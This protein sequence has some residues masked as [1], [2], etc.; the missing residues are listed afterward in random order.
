MIL[1]GY[2]PVWMSEE[3]DML[4]E[5]AGRFAREEIAPKDAEWRQQHQVDHATW[6]L[7]GELGLLLTDVPESYGGAGGHF[8]HEAVIYRALASVSD[9]AFVA[10]RSVHAIVSHYL[11]ACGTEAQ[12]QRWL[13]AMASG[14]CIGG[15]AMTEPGAGSDLQGVRTK[16]EKRG[17]N[18]LI[19]GAK[20]FISNGATAGMIIVVAKTDPSLGAK[21]VSLFLL[22]TATQ[23]FRVG[24]VLD[25]IGL[26]GQDTCELF[27]DD[28]LV[29]AA[30]LL[31][32]VE[33]MGFAQLMQQ[34]PYERSI[35]S[36]SAAASI[37]RALQLAVEY[38]RE[39]TVFGKPL[40]EMQNTRF[41][42]AEVKTVATV[43]RIF[44]DFL[45][46]RVIKG[47][48]DSVTASMGKWWSTEAQCQAV[49]AC[50][51]LFGGYGYMK[52]YP[53]ARMYADARVQ[54]IYGG[55]NEI[56]KELIARSL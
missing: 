56:M 48:L 33:G 10:G 44:N 34:L 35:I 40:I 18:Y 26:D 37:E 52:E 39:R 55:A 29:P 14:A 20:T 53:I 31:G 9:S 22:D 41:E 21:G 27:F 13:P 4:S 36:V 54:K 16:A 6:N 17:D 8:G 11:L 15:I 12:R 24:R 5:A 51:Q 2:R 1:P 7:A 43:A 3:L 46:E 38:T 25:K 19:N 47:E 23:G 45:I 28:C 30:N 49:D 32:G 50:L 42:L